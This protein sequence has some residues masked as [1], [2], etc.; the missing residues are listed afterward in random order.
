MGGG[1]G[2]R[3]AGGVLRYQ[4]RQKIAHHIGFSGQVDVMRIET[5]HFT[6]IAAIECHRAIAAWWRRTCRRQT[7]RGQREHPQSKHDDNPSNARAAYHIIRRRGGES[8]SKFL[9]RKDDLKMDRK[10]LPL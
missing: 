4:S 2:H 8:S 3:F 1:P 9:L 7:K 5:F 6:A 10:A